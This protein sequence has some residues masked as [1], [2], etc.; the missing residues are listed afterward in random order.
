M[1]V[2]RDKPLIERELKFAG[3]DLD[4]LRQRLLELEAE[5]I[6][7][8]AEENNWLLDRDGELAERGAILRVRDDGRGAL[9]TFK[10]PASFEGTTKLRVEHEFRM[11][12]AESAMALF[13]ALGY[14]TGRR[15]QKIR[16]EWRLGGEIIAL[17]RTPIGDFVE[18]EGDRAEAIAKRCG[19]DPKIAVRSSY[20]ML[21]QEYLRDHPEAPRDMIFPT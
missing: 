20:L 5:R 9:V 3:V 18:F 15:Y 8:P 14:R 12:N 7:P 2:K 11:D 4:T 6:A 21:Y 1:T 17:D 19:Y 10:G 16:E 13:E